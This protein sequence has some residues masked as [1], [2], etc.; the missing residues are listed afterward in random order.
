MRWMIGLFFSSAL[1]ISCGEKEKEV[2]FLD[3]Y[4]KEVAVGYGSY[5][6]CEQRP[7]AGG[8]DNVTG[9]YVSV[10]SVR[11]R[12]LSSTTGFVPANISLSMEIPGIGPY[13]CD[14]DGDKVLRLFGLPPAGLRP[15]T[16]SDTCDNGETL[17]CLEVSSDAGGACSFS[18][19]E[20][21]LDESSPFLVPATIAVRGAS[22]DSGTGAADFI[23]TSSRVR[24]KFAK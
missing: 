4:P 13:T 20:L 17:G 9:Y 2:L 24:V 7:A 11:L 5:Q 1:M 8:L 23:E 10:A 14:L 19:G 21:P 15:V 18:C 22:V 16:D 3:T 12:W 6:P